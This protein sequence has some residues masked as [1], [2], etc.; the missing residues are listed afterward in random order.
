MVELRNIAVYRDSKPI[1][2]NVSGSINA[3][4]FVIIVG[5][6][7]AGKTTLFDVLAGQLEPAAGSLIING[8]DVT[9]KLLPDRALLVSRLLQNPSSNI[10]LNCTVQENIALSMTRGRSALLKRIDQKKYYTIKEQLRFFGLD[11]DLILRTKM[12]DLSGGQKQQVAFVMATSAGNP[13]LL[14]LDEPTA[15]LDPISTTK[16]LTQAAQFIKKN[17]L[18]TIMITHD[19]KLALALANKVWIINNGTLFKQYNT[20]EALNEL[21]P[22]TLIE[23]IPYGSLQID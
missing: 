11:S 19:L 5:P 2:Q 12:S 14:L 18:T 20:K 4:D 21:K 3:G 1:L 17:H 13:K 6:N 8:A 15:A 23:E 16:L 9:R 22:E 7:G 10:I